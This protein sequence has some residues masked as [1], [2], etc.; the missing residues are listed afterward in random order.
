MI[1]VAGLATRTVLLVDGFSFVLVRSRYLPHGLRVEDRLGGVDSV[2]L[3]QRQKCRT[4]L[5]DFLISDE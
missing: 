3:E 4:P 5:V 1:S 2:F